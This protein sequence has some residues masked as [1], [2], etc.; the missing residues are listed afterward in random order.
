MNRDHI[1]QV[2]DMKYEQSFA[3]SGID[4]PNNNGI[5]FVASVE[6]APMACQI[7]GHRMYG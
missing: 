5:N 6:V 4:A 7:F 3:R 1:D 2:E